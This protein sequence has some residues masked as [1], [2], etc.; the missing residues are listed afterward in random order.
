[1]TPLGLL[2]RP[3][4]HWGE[5]SFNASRDGGSRKHEGIDLVAWPRTPVVAWTHGLKFV[6]LA[7]PYENDPR[8]SG[9]LF[10]IGNGRQVKIFYVATE[11]HLAPGLILSR[12]DAIGTVQDLNMR[13]AGITPHVHFELWEG[14]V[15]IDPTPYLRGGPLT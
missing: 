15:R 12:G 5:G 11:P 10:D 4:D 1:M 7:P 6:R 9:V 13:Y 14:G 8:F 3:R 2:I